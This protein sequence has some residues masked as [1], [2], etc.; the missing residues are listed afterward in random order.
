M[1]HQD[2]SGK[3]A[4]GVG[5]T[6]WDAGIVLA[7]YFEHQVNEGSDCFEDV[8]ILELGSGTGLCGLV[9]AHLGARIT[10]T[11][12]GMSMDLLKHNVQCSIPYSARLAKNKDNKPPKV[13]LRELSWGDALYTTTQD[14]ASQISNIS[15]VSSDSKSSRRNGGPNGSTKSC[16]TVESDVEV[17]PDRAGVEETFDI[18]VGSDIVIW[19]ELF[20][21]LIDTLLKVTHADTDVYL[22][23]EERKTQVTEQFFNLLKLS[24]SYEV[25]P[26]EDLHPEYQDQG[27]KIYHIK[28]L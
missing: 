12:R 9:L 18:V 16:C 3:W 1:I 22:S 28:R 4:G 5:S 14:S 21:P 15:S 23:Y 26:I 24:F 27:I 2:P 6:I 20:Q 8:S 17:D 13:K 25:I 10:L 19:P 11:D 7:R